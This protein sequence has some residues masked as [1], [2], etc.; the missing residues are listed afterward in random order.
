[1]CIYTPPN[2]LQVNTEYLN[3]LKVLA[4]FAV[5]VY[6]VV[7]PLVSFH[8]LAL[9]DFE[10]NTCLVFYNLL[11]WHVPVFVMITGALLLN[12]EKEITILKLFKKYI[13]RII[14]ALFVF[15]FPFAFLEIYFD[16]H[17]QFNIK[18]IYYAFVNIFD[19]NRMW[20]HMWY[21]YMVI[22]LYLVIPLIKG[23]ISY[24][25]KSTV[26]YI[27]ILLFIFTSIIP[28]FERILGF[29]FFISIPVNSIYVFYLIFGYYLH[30]YKVMLNCKLLVFLLSLFIISVVLSIINIH[31]GTIIQLGYD[32][33]FVI[34]AASVIFCLVRQR[35][36]FSKITNVL[37]F[38]CFGIYLIHPL[39]I[40]FLYK[41][42]KL[43]PERY[44]L[45]MDVFITGI[46]TIIL[47]IGFTFYARKINIIR[48]YLL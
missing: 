2:C 39:F 44:P 28:Y 3:T 24:A 33:P 11:N 17:Y 47:S 42:L 25:E 27:L 43:I 18:Q 8:S 46:V 6:H 13:S 45:I 36:K 40:N 22:G 16:A 37:S 23:F 26:E 14:F 34:L 7:K 9:S 38:L 35:N 31:A 48:K 15:G 4:A 5:L 20:D 19:Q 1:M 32:S 10:R 12:P 21:L 41:F 29:R 30:N